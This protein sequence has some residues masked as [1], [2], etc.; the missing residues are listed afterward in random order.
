MVASA[1]STSASPLLTCLL[2]ILCFNLN[3]TFQDAFSLDLNW[4]R[5]PSSL[6]HCPFTSLD[7]M[8]TSALDD[9][10]GTASHCFILSCSFSIHLMTIHD[11]EPMVCIELN[12]I[13]DSAWGSHGSSVIHCS[14]FESHSNVSFLSKL[15][16]TSVIVPPFV[17][18]S[19]VYALLALNP[20][21]YVPVPVSRLGNGVSW[22]LH[23]SKQAGR[24]L[25]Y[26]YSMHV[27]SESKRNL[28]RVLCSRRRVLLCLQLRKGRKLKKTWTG[29]TKKSEMGLMW[30]TFSERWN[31]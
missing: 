5:L 8:E 14:L 2:Y 11:G 16:R 22:S 12:W 4:L 3:N 19:T 25:N 17:A 18:P 13:C 20:H 30:V 15:Y 24:G 10:L 6:S 7:Q 9:V 26:N 23:Q 21:I 31:L 1:C 28:F 27:F 29:V